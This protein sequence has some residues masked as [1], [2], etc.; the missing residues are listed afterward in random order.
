VILLAISVGFNYAAAEAIGATEK[1]PRLQAAC[2]TAAIAGNVSALVYYKYLAWLTQAAAGLGL[3]HSA[4]PNIVLPLGI[5][6][7][8]FTQIG[9]LIDKKQGVTNDRG[10]L[11]YVLFVTFFPHLI[12]GPI[13]HN[14][15]MMPQFGDDATYRFSGENF[16][17][18]LSVFAIGLAKKCLLAD[19][20]SATVTAGFSN[21]SH[22]P[23]FGAWNVALC[24]TLQIYFDF[25]GYSDM[26]IGL[27]RMFNVRFP[28]NFNS[29]YKATSIIEHWQRWHMTLTRYLNLYL[30]NPIALAVTN[31]RA[32]R[33]LGIAKS[34]QAKPG[35]FATMV[36]LPTVATMGIAGV[37]HGAGL[38]YVI[39]GLLHGIYLTINHAVRIF[40]P[41]SPGK[42]DDSAVVHGSKLLLTHLAVVVSLIFFR[43]PTVGSALNVLGGMIGLHGPGGLE[44]PNFVLARLGNLGDALTS[45]GIITSVS[46]GFFAADAGQVVWMI[47]LYATVWCLPNT[48][49]IMRDFAPALGRVQPGRFE[50]LTWQPTAGWA[51]A[52]G[53]LAS[54]GVLAISGTTEFL[55][56][57]F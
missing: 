55:Y 54:I 2:L 26:A 23:L 7:F 14:R 41:R 45:H 4:M 19:P 20:L 37:W 24:Y 21:P 40:R 34:A 29:P 28:L 1:R 27:A 33:G 25:S 43:A 48:Q 36:M 47:L 12:A 5:S 50:R 52:I 32:E 16:A 9:Y 3:I 11:N 53:V 46:Q 10:L 56:F 22:L 6:F 39:F 51:V 30:Y 15:E 8:T 35:G 17:V 31:W 49:Q 44:L 42:R 57:Q 18:G 13:L 38:Q